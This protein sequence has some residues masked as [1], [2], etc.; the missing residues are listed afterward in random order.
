MK[1]FTPG[2]ATAGGVPISFRYTP[3]YTTPDMAKVA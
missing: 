2:L 3:A 1:N